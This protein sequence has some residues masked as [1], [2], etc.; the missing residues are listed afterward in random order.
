VITRSGKTACQIRSDDVGCQVQWRVPTP[1]LYGAP[2]NGVRVS[3]NGDWDWVTGDMGN[4]S[5]TTLTYGTAYRS[6]GWT[7]TPTSDGTTFL[8]DATG[9]GM[10]VGVQGVEPF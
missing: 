10:T 3:A 2:A 4:Q 8:N 1:L 6:L 5:Y 7:I 9:R